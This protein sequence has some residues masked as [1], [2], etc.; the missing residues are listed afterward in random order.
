MMGAYKRSLGPSIKQ[1]IHKVRTAEQV[2]A[3]NELSLHFVLIPA[4]VL[5]GYRYVWYPVFSLPESSNAVI[6]EAISLS[7]ALVRA[8][9]LVTAII[10]LALFTPMKTILDRAFCS[11][12]CTILCAVSLSGVHVGP[13]CSIRHGPSTRRP[14]GE[15]LKCYVPNILVDRISAGEGTDLAVTPVV[16]MMVDMVNFTGI[17]DTISRAAHRSMMEYVTTIYPLLTQHLL[18]HHLHQHPEFIRYGR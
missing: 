5:V 14:L 1:L 4:L 15:I 17:T 8:S 18:H 2:I 10:L 3:I 12:R 6:A 7:R 11:H 16:C 13:S 9:L